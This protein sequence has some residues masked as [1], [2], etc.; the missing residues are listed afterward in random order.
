MRGAGFSAFGA[1]LAAAGVALG[2]WAAHG[3]DAVAAGHASTASLHAMLHGIGLVALGLAARSRLQRA[4]A[5]LI[6]VGAG[7]FCGSLAMSALAATTT[8]AAPFGGGLLILGWLL[9]AVAL[10]RDRRS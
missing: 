3:L 7:V 1:L 4:A 2:A 5:T 9:A 8:A 6:A 10:L